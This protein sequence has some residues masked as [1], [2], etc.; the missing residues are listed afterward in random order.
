MAQLER[1][2]ALTRQHME[3]ANAACHAAVRRDFRRLFAALVPTKQ[4]DLVRDAERGALTFAI[5][6]LGGQ[7]LLAWGVCGAV[8]TC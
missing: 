1:G 5:H 7:A 3:A 4:A 2:A 6:N 8:L